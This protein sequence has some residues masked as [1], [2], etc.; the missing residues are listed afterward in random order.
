MLLHFLLSQ[1]L[2]LKCFKCARKLTEERSLHV[3]APGCSRGLSIEH[4]SIKKKNKMIISRLYKSVNSNIT[5]TL[6]VILDSNK[7]KCTN[8]YQY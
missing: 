6:L 1:F 5:N 4:Q 7:I 8:A 2:H 3:V